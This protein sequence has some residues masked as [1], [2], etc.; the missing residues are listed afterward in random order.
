MDTKENILQLLG[1][2]G[3]FGILLLVLSLIFASAPYLSGYDFGPIKIPKFTKTI[4][5]RL[6]FIGPISLVIAIGLHYHFLS[7]S[8]TQTNRTVLS[9]VY[10]LHLYN[11]D[12]IA[13]LNIND[14]VRYKVKWGYQGYEPNWF[15]FA[16]YGP[17]IINSKPGDSQV[18][19]ITSDLQPGD[20]ILRLTLWDSGISPGAASCFISVKKNGQELIGDLFSASHYT[21][22][23]KPHSAYE[24]NFH[25]QY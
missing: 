15:P 8:E 3:E 17:A 9:D 22:P 10:T 21:S 23:G 19:N 5:T 13:E 24:R 18:I 16:E 20:N 1:L 12:D 14:R 6:K 7:I 4:K 11:V 25:V 2:L